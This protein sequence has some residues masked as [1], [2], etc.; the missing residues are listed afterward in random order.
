MLTIVFIMAKT[1]LIM[2]TIVSN[3]LPMIGNY[4]QNPQITQRNEV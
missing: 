2:H 4:M 1:E 3:T